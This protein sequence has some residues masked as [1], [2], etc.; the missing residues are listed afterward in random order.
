MHCNLIQ[1]VSRPIQ[2]IFYSLLTQTSKKSLN[3]HRKDTTSFSF[4]IFHRI[5]YHI[6]SFFFPGGDT[7]LWLPIENERS[8]L[9]NKMNFD[10]FYSWEEF[11]TLEA[12]N[13]IRTIHSGRLNSEIEA[14]F[15]NSIDI[16]KIYIK[17][18]LSNSLINCASSTVFV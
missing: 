7:L 5:C 18:P 2:H 4:N 10:M 1:R 15:Q 8:S 6:V 3:G 9:E 17:K 14:E 11:W 13:L 16:G 12:L